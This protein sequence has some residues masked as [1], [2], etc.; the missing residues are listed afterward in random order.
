MNEKL[1]LPEVPPALSAEQ[2][3]AMTDDE[4]KTESE[5]R[6][7]LYCTIGDLEYRFGTA[8][9]SVRY[10]LESRVARATMRAEILAEMKGNPAP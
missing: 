7:D 5:R 9:T 3:D 8:W 6:Y 2:M 4:L 10:Y 1:T